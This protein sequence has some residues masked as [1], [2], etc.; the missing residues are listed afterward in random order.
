MIVHEGGGVLNKLIDKLPV[1]LHL[2]GYQFCGPGTRLG[3]RLARGDPGVNP[4]DAACK[5]HDIAYSSHQDVK[6][7]HLADAVL[8]QEAWKRVKAKDSSVSEKANAWL[9]TNVMKAKR[10]LGM[11]FGR[12]GG[13]GGNKQSKVAFGRIVKT[14]LNAVKGAQAETIAKA[15]KIAVGAARRAVKEA[16]GRRCVR[17]PRVIPIPGGAVKQGGLLPLLPAIFGGLAALGSLAG[18][19]SQVVKA[20]KD[21]KSAKDQLAEMKDHNR[22]MEGIAI[23]KGGSMIIKHRSS[24][25][26]GLGL[27][28]SKKPKS[29]GRGLYLRK[30]PTKN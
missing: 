11:G 20:V 13:G 8:E 19:V 2:P 29:G 4:L 1:E 6:S 24:S 10:K 22:R 26:S 23:G 28:L 15:A 16:G 25:K 3:Q 27:Y 17:Q 7:R 21:V 12:G 5:E 18:G 14:G 30:K 9:V